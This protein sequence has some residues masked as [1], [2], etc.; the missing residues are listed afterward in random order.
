MEG[1][2]IPVKVADSFTR[3][4]IYHLLAIGFKYPTRE[5]FELYQSGNF[6][7]E[8]LKLLTSLPRL[9]G[10]ALEEASTRDK[11]NLDL[12]GVDYRDFEAKYVTT[13]DA[14]FPEIPCPLYSGLY[15]NGIPRSE[16]LLELAAFYKHF[17]LAMSQEESTRE[18]QDHLCAELEFL[19]LLSL[20]EFKAR[21]EKQS[22]LLSSYLLAQKDFLER[23]MI[24]WFPKFLEKV[25]QVDRL[26][27]YPDLARITMRFT[28]CEYK[29]INALTDLD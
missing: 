22:S 25:Q 3:S 20:K 26:P 2:E 19:H 24:D 11:V 5:W 8:I 15:P 10:I 16:A 7:A 4:Q 1:E 14:G 29:F 23:H 21:Q 9:S 12:K 28:N 27:F 18:G 17:G 13:F 6:I